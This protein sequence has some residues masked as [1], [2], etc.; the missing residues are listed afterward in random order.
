M[1][2]D[3]VVH[4]ARLET[5]FLALMEDRPYSIG[6]HEN[7]QNVAS[8]ATDNIMNIFKVLRTIATEESNAATMKY[9]CK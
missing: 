3:G 5:G 7:R 2:C 8:E 6:Q 4:G 9:V 1:G